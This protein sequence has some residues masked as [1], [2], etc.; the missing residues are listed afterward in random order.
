MNSLFIKDFRFGLD[1][2]K[3][4]LTQRP[5]TLE[6]LQ[7]GYINQGGEIQNRKAFV[8]TT[9][10]A[11]TFGLQPTSN[12]LYTFGSKDLAAN[13]PVNIGTAGIPIY[14]NYQ[15]LY[16]PAVL[17]SA[18]LYDAAKHDMTQVIFSSEFRGKAFVIAKFADGTRYC[19]YD[20]TLLNDSV[21]G[22][23]LTYLAGNNRRIADH[24]KAQV[25][26]LSNYSATRVGPYTTTRREHSVLDATLTIGAHGFQ[27][28]DKI[29]VSGI[30]TEGYNVTAAPVTAITATKVMYTTAVDL[31]EVD[32]E[33]VGGTVES[34]IVNVEGEAGVDYTLAADNT[35]VAGTMVGPTN[36]VSPVSAVSGASAKG[37]FYITGGTQISTVPGSAVGALTSTATNAVAGEVVTVGNK[38]YTFRAAP[39]IEG[40]VLIGANAAASLL[41]LKNAITHGGTPGTD[42]VCARAHPW[43]KTAVIAGSPGVLTLT[44]Y[45]GSQGAT[46]VTTT[47]SATWTWGAAVMSA[48]GVGNCVGS[49]KVISPTGSETELLGSAVAFTTNVAATA[50]AVRDAIIAYTGTSGYTAEVNGNQVTVLS[51]DSANPMPNDYH[52]QVAAGGDVTIGESSFH[53]AQQATS[54]TISTIQVDGLDCLSGGKLFP[55][56]SIN[57]LPEY[58]Q[59]LV[60][61]INSRTGITGINAW[62]EGNYVKLS[63]ITTRDDDV[64]LTIYITPSAANQVGIVFNTP[65]PLVVP[66]IVTLP[67][68]IFPL[69]NAGIRS[70]SGLFSF[71]IS[72]DVTADIKGG[73]GL[74]T[75]EW[76]Q[77]YTGSDAGV[78]TQNRGVYGIWSM[79]YTITISPP[80][81]RT[82]RVLFNAGPDYTGSVTDVD[83]VT[84]N[85]TIRCR[86]TDSFGNKATSDTCAVKFQ[87]T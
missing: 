61:T 30:A 4:E 33:E 39:A 9:R 74:Y 64:S 7:N 81:G 47:T 71:T 73:N 21:A 8:R 78:V 48:A 29:W 40:E 59:D 3:S 16:H 11:G 18:L 19:Y 80:G 28:G 32:T 23:V 79:N 54:F 34:A 58:Y 82:I 43:I 57:T 55:S 68:E 76:I 15:R 70:G 65:P 86:V 60:S 62:T 87:I 2:R 14:V 10:V 36:T 53:L 66:L 75:I 41:N 85:Y 1:T 45:A 27:I 84:I 44:A 63:R 12:G 46:I 49:I 52:L 69:A 35:T 6:V 13:H 37:S 67:T 25:D 22:K 31:T 72:A 50:A 5:G 77:E 20:G 56:P 42:Y 26:A 38:K 51:A 83:P 24:M 17:Y